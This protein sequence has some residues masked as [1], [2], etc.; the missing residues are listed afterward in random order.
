MAEIKYINVRKEFDRFFK[1]VISKSRDNLK[2]LGKNASG[3]LSKSL[4]YKIIESANSIDADF[5]MESYGDFVDKGVKGVS[6]GTSLAGYKYTDKK[7]PLAPL[8]TWAKRKTG[9]FRERNATHRAFAIQ[10]V[11]YQRGLP[12]TRFFSKP[13]ED[14]FKNLPDEIVEAYGLDVEDFMEFVLN[15]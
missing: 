13:F 12:P 3:D 2:S 9:K 4:D 7:P 6:S 8:R 10:N 11:I 1:A 5:L 15:D 14:E